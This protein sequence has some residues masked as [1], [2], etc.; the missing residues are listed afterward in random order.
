[1]LY[2]NWKFD[3]YVLISTVLFHAFDVHMKSERNARYV[4]C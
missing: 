2:D 4:S 1:M 3:R